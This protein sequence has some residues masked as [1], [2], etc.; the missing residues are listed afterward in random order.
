MLPSTGPCD[1]NKCR[2]GGTCYVIRDKGL[3]GCQSNYTGNLCQYHIS[4]DQN[5]CNQLNCLHGGV[6]QVSP[7]SPGLSYKIKI[8]MI[9]L[10]LNYLHHV[11]AMNTVMFLS[12]YNLFLFCFF[13]L[14]ILMWYSEKP[15]QKSVL[16]FGEWYFVICSFGYSDTWCNVYGKFSLW[17][18]FL[19]DNIQCSKVHLSWRLGWRKLWVID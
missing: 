7:S 4:P 6:C 3:C 16:L 5:Q 1:P 10:S 11:S 17:H 9:N 19:S 18:S 12:F 8:T 15:T 2:N 14:Q 13:I